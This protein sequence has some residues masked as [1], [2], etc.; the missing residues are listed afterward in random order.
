MA[1]LLTILALA[2]L[3][4]K[5]GTTFRE[6]MFGYD[7]VFDIILTVLFIQLFASTGTIS[8]MMTAITAGLIVS[9][10]L[11]VG[12]KL[13]TSRKVALTR[14]GWTLRYTWIITPGYFTHYKRR[15]YHG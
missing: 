9:V 2:F 5:F 14:D 1:A 8:G 11:Y 15:S 10:A 7:V 3:F 13:F 4:A 6:F 12:K